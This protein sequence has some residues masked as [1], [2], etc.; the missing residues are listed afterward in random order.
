MHLLTHS[1]SNS[2]NQVRKHRKFCLP[3]PWFSK[4]FVYFTRIETSLCLSLT[5][6]FLKLLT[7]MPDADSIYPLPDSLI[8]FRVGSLKLSSSFQLTGR[9]EAF[10][11]PAPWFSSYTFTTFLE[12]YN[13]SVLIN[14]VGNR[15]SWL[16]LQR[17][18]FIL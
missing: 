11:L 5:K 16:V 6:I 1:P 9:S 18:L 8:L 14:K 15:W 4:E 13:T 2:T 12:G 10:C 17:Q 7:H 3:G